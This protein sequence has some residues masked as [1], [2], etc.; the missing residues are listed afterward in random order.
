[1]ICGCPEKIVPR[2]DFRATFT[3]LDPLESY[4]PMVSREDL[5]SILGLPPQAISPKPHERATRASSASSSRS[6]MSNRN[7]QDTSLKSDEDNGW[8]N[9]GDN[10]SLYGASDDEEFIAT[11]RASPS[12]S[13]PQSPS[14]RRNSINEEGTHPTQRGVDEITELQVRAHSISLNFRRANCHP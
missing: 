13:P 14:S 9:E 4:F 2:K 3:G 8:D 11:P 6:S 12:P 5:H 1:M 10:A 7:I